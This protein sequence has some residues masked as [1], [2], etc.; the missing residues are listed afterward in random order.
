MNNAVCKILAL[1]I[2]LHP[3]LG[4]SLTP[5]PE[6]ASSPGGR[7]TKPYI[8]KRKVVRTDATEKSKA[9]QKVE[10]LESGKVTVL[11]TSNGKIVVAPT[12]VAPTDESLAS[13]SGT[14]ESG[15]SESES[16]KKSGYHDPLEGF[17][18]AIFGFNNFTYRYALIPAA[19]GYR[20]VTPAGVR[21]RISNLFDNLTEPL[22]LVNNLV[23]LD[24]ADAGKN[25]KRFLINSTVGVLGL[26]DPAKHWFDIEEADQSF[27]DTLSRYQ[28]PSGPYLVLPILGQS[29]VRNASSILT[30]ALA[31]P[32]SIIVSRPESS[33]ILGFGSFNS[34]SFQSDLYREL[35]EQA[36]DPYVY[37]R[38]QYIQGRN[39]DKL[40]E[41][42]TPAE[43]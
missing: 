30:E 43:K 38:N 4:C 27:S 35:Y 21:L 11:E 12:V 1:C 6:T 9:T 17:N 26:F 34:F 2:V 24:G 7:L 36:E 3:A 40:F 28:V 23:T 32:L 33:Y 18:R 22:N 37:F 13:E 8:A 42:K 20:Y 10:E 31:N 5:G 16:V 41:Q 39:R 25:I 29:D 15:T 14:S 19:K